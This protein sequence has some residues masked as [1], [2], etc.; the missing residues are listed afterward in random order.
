MKEKIEIK[1][2]FKIDDS[3][4]NIRGF[5]VLKQDD[6]TV[7]FKKENMIVKKGREFILKKLMGEEV[8]AEDGI[9]PVT[10]SNGKIEFNNSTEMT[11]PLDESLKGSELAPISINFSSSNLSYTDLITTITVSITG[12]T[13]II[14]ELG[15][16][17]SDD[18]LFSRV[19][20]EP[21]SVSST[22]SYTLTYYIYF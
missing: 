16:F 14:S 12:E 7:L 5:A 18:S 9:T 17:L 22:T 2:Y 8:L 13:K 11:T 3:H 6:G 19:V 10:F 20:F 15:I 21:V 4:S 1:D